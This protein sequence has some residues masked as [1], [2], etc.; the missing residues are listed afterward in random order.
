MPSEE[1]VT[2]VEAD[3]VVANVAAD[4]IELDRANGTGNLEGG[5]A[6]VE[7]IEVALVGGQS[8]LDDDCD[9]REEDDDVGSPAAAAPALTPSLEEGEERLR[10]RFCRLITLALLTWF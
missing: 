10:L 3:R 1:L 6:E 2:D 7:G 4:L 9:D 5:G 8:C